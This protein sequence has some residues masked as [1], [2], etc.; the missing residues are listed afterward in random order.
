MEV[1][2]YHANGGLVLVVAD[3]HVDFT[4]IQT[5][6]TDASGNYNVVYTL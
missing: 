6:F 3:D 1:N 5:F 4:D 2:I